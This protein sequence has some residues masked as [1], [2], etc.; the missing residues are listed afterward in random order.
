MTVKNP[1]HNKDLYLENARENNLKN[2]SLTIPHDT[3]TVVT[4]LSGSG[5]SSL[6]FD[7]VYAEGQR[8]YIETFSPYTR[9][10]F[11]KVKKPEIDSVQNVR[12]A[13]AIQQRTKIT[14]ARSTVGSL[15]NINDYLKVLFANMS[16]PVCPVCGNTLIA[17]TPS[18]IAKHLKDLCTITPLNLFIGSSV[19]I[20]KKHKD[21][22][23]ERFRTL[24]FTR[25]WNYKTD[26]IVSLEA[27]LPK[28][29]PLLDG[30]ALIILDRF[31]ADSFNERRARSS[32]E[33]AFSL[34][35]GSAT[36]IYENDSIFKR[37]VF[38]SDYFCE[39]H[40]IKVK[41]PK[42]YLFS[43]NH[44]LG[45]CS[46]CKGF[47]FNLEISR[48]KCVPDPSKSLE[49]YAIQCWSGPSAS[50]E[51]RDLLKFCKKEGIKTD[52]PWSRLSATETG[53]I[54]THKSKEFWGILPWFAWLERKKY[55]MHV[56]VFL[57]RYRDPV[58]CQS[59]H[60][61]RLRPEA[62]SFKLR[63][64]TIS[65]L[66][67]MNVGELYSWL[68]EILADSSFNDGHKKQLRDV[69][70]NLLS[71]LLYL[72]D[73]GL[74]YLTLDRQART[75]SGGETQRVNL[76]GALGS[77]LVS[78]QFVLD[79]PS[80][81][82]HARDSERLIE[83]V[84]RLTTK[85]N[86]LLVVE[87]DP[88]FIYS[89]DTILELGPKAGSHGGSITYQGPT[90]KWA[91]IKAKIPSFSKKQDANS[92]KLSKSIEVKNAY[93]RNLKNIDVS[94]PLGRFVCLTGVS[95]SGKSTLI[96]EIIEHAYLKK[97]DSEKLYD[98]VSGFQ[99]IGDLLIINQTPLA[100]SPRA[101]IAT[102]TKMWDTIRE[103]LASTESAKG[104]GLTKS[105]FSF[106]VNAGR[107]TTCEG[108]GF[109]REDMQ[110]LSDVFIPC[111]SCLGKRFQPLV[112][113]V[114][115]GGKNVDDFLKMTVEDACDFFHEHRD[116]REAA[117][118]LA[119]LGLGSL[120]LGHSLSELSG[121]EAQRLKLIPFLKRDKEEKVLLVF[122][123]P[124]T[125]LHLYD[126]EKLLGLFQVLVEKGHS[127][128]CVEHNLSV[129]AHAD[130][131]I[132][133][134][135]EGGF[136]GG[137]VIAIG[138]P[139]E[140]I[141]EKSSYTGSYLAQYIIN[142][143]SN[144]KAIKRKH[145]ARSFDSHD[146]KIEGAR[147]HNLKNISLSIPSNKLVAITGVSG[148][149][150][151]TVAKDIIYAEGQR[152]YLDCLS[153]YARQF[154]KE[155]KKPDID[156]IENVRPTICVY[157]HTFQ[158]SSLSTVG[159]MSEV[160]N[161]LRLLFAK[162]GTQY[163]PEH[164]DQAITSLSSQEIATEL[165]SLKAQT[166][167]ILAPVVKLKKGNHTAVLVRAM[168]TD[169]AEV[170]VDGIFGR[171]SQFM[172][173]L[174]KSK[175]HSV[176]YVVAK[177]NTKTATADLVEEGV[178]AA[179]TLG[180]GIV[181]G[182]TTE[183]E[184]VYSS[185]RTCPICKKGFFKADPEDLSFHSKRGACSECSGTGMVKGSPCKI[186]HGSRISLAGQNIRISGKNIFEAVNQPVKSL[187]VF[188]EEY[189]K[190]ASV[191][192][193]VDPILRELRSKLSSLI[194][195]GLDFLNLNRDCSSL[196]G[197]EL[198]RLRLATA[199]GSPL[200]G[201]LYIFDEPSAGLHPLDNEKVL[202]KL[203]SLRDDGNTIIII[204]HDVQSI[205]ACDYAIDI[206]PGAGIHGGEVVYTGSISG[207]MHTPTPTGK[208]LCEMPYLNKERSSLQSKPQCRVSNAATNNLKNI[209]LS[210]P[211]QSL[212]VVGGVS[213]AGK[214]SLVH[215]TIARAL[216]EGKKKNDTFLFEK[217]SVS[218]ELTVH[219]VVYIDQKPLGANSRSTPASYLGIWD[220]V[221]KL[222][223][224]TLEAKSL[225]WEMGH[226][227]YNTGKGRCPACKGAG[228]IKLEMNFLAEAEVLCD[229]CS[230]SR[231]NDTIEM[232][233]YSGLSISDCLK[234][235]F[236]EAKEKFA[237]H[238]KIHSVLKNACDLGLGYLTIGQ[239]STTLSGGESQRLRLISE[240][241]GAVRGHTLYILD[242]PTLGLHRSDV[243]M[244]LLSLKKLVA[245]GHSVI[246]IE[247][248]IDTICASDYFIEL[249]PEAGENG[250]TIIFSGSPLELAKSRSPWGNI[251]SDD[252]ILPSCEAAAAQVEAVS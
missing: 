154:I 119:Q 3:L 100:K 241:S 70:S 139:A 208:A 198:Q 232:V 85:G 144:F 158:P 2:L 5:K 32:L 67:K 250:G 107:C 80:V 58:L 160:Y 77:E 201:V 214:S 128:L 51:H 221:R 233:R 11:D 224:K 185:E 17:W 130:W 237:N 55:K 244:L 238:R 4:G 204:E 174:Q 63:D 183:A 87:H 186:C 127:I 143:Q 146:L 182:F 122:D 111:E 193:I 159:T 155:L 31:K 97:Q 57:S 117:A 187:L 123:E 163:C 206:G 176:E 234:L 92:S 138:T 145:H 36:V 99:N 147:E 211:L 6:A 140:I 222:F 27:I 196:S 245:L 48:H 192:E 41:K 69:F 50:H 172:N 162:T 191:S 195:L 189:K 178:K 90:E 251:L 104:R 56:R 171:P 33:Q 247:H 236:E 124:T 218:P 216:Q 10:F 43:F 120:T 22:E 135:P 60:G 39:E 74:P 86:S 54:F 231:Y 121:G 7:T 35:Q 13:I 105:S 156:H 64:K 118:N 24:G 91:G 199:M 9:Q 40:A 116:I 150:K 72:K 190:I 164:P 188:L 1:Q 248:D 125:G 37:R 205:K 169:V 49:E 161:F 102:Y 177:F 126:I 89:A 132:D 213:G 194:F 16:R 106:N 166:V 71:R 109:I 249:G 137:A 95:G 83:A 114:A 47:G 25:C 23:L 242:E 59:C 75:L 68:N 215:G 131:V 202:Q 226:F 15:T 73:L 151:S 229:V 62:L 65:D 21:L 141:Q 197:G 19:L 61:S 30:K 82:L 210:F 239:S 136:E 168:K 42:Q 29:L 180:G 134:G 246:V 79:E 184:Y 167:R 44:P 12:P 101:N 84:Q 228:I 173:E 220:E 252:F 157:Q 66:W 230:G 153:P 148:S 113:E 179:L 46:E 152:R 18:Q 212:V 225:G 223:A 103:L 235:T 112:L 243:Q 78:T 34:A 115:Y 170:R 165:L 76:A 203:S 175:A 217:G 96:H 20:N 129:I 98:S 26:E 133:L 53:K 149:G 93:A 227:S 28:E 38:H 52:I 219:K 181:V 81:G 8:R 200:S 207:L 142:V 108:A 110:F 14:S 209:S 88:D 240:L 45:A 94:I